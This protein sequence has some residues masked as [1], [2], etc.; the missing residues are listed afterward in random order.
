MAYPKG[1]SPHRY[2][3]GG[4]VRTLLAV[5]ADCVGLACPHCGN[6]LVRSSTGYSEYVHCPISPNLFVDPFAVDLLWRFS[7]SGISPK[8][9]STLDDVRKELKEDSPP[10]PREGSLSLMDVATS[11]DLPWKKL[12]S[13][14]ALLYPTPKTPGELSAEI[15]ALAVATEGGSLSMTDA[16]L[17]ILNK[18]AAPT[19]A[20]NTKVPDSK[21]EAGFPY[22]RFRKLADAVQAAQ[23]QGKVGSGYS[24]RREIMTAR[25]WGSLQ[26]E[27][28]SEAALQLAFALVGSERATE[29]ERPFYEELWQAQMGTRLYPLPSLK[30]PKGKKGETWH[31]QAGLALAVVKSGIPLWLSGEAGAGKTYL[32]RQIA[33]LCELPYVRLQGSRDRTV[34]DVIGA[35][36]YDPAVGS[37]FRPGVVVET[38]RTGGVLHIDEVSA[39]PHEV[40][41]E[42]HAVL[43]G[44]PIT[45]L[46]N[47][48][49]KV[50]LNER[51]RMVANDNSVGE[52]EQASYVGLHSTNLAFRDRWAF[53]RVK[54]MPAK[55]REKLIM[56]A[57]GK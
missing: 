16:V 46:K 29:D 52:G 13:S 4:E 51:F 24:L 53:L 23:G 43:E 35:W 33:N 48:G 6:A 42:L 1:F 37:V 8:M 3:P 17:A 21:P 10:T 20:K 47:S 15:A 54:P 28:G 50:A 2:H 38:A 9:T 25:L 14:R 18:D 57:A 12:H 36:G 34:D 27:T 40:T 26:E 49:E 11:L 22:S 30:A 19:M 55:F 45:V 39:L 44:E 56:E 31:P 32:T 5:E 7:R 41:F